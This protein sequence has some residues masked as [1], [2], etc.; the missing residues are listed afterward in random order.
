MGDGRAREP[1]QAGALSVMI[2]APAKRRRKSTGMFSPTA[3]HGCRRQSFCL[4]E[5]WTCSISRYWFDGPKKGTKELGLGNLP[6]YPDNINRASDGNYWLAL[7]GM[8]DPGTGPRPPHAGIPQ[9]M[10]RRVAP[11]HWLYPE[12]QHGLR[13]QVRREWARS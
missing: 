12:H 10:A 4:A 6:G 13:R 2:P 7:L 3:S 9:R 1:R 11:D 5:S 8:P